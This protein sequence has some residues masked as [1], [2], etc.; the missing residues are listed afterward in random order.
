ML[1]YMLHYTM[2]EIWVEA[3]KEA[4]GDIL[5]DGVR[6]PGA[7]DAGSRIATDGEPAQVLDA[8]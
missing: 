5:G 4:K 3:W 8:Q 1:E 2:L 6:E 7:K